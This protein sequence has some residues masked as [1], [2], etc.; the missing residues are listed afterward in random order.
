M[1]GVSKLASGVI[2]VMVSVVRSR[3]VFAAADVGRQGS[4][5]AA[6]TAMRLY[7]RP[8]RV[9]AAERRNRN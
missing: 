9:R 5:G 4:G 8:D 7:L 1:S 3:A 2:A 6:E